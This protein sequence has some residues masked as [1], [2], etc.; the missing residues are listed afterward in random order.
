MRFHN[1]AASAA[2]EA[3][4]HRVPYRHT[5]ARFLSP[6]KYCHPSILN[7][8][9][10]AHVLDRFSRSARNARLTIMIRGL[11]L[12]KRLWL[13]LNME[14]VKNCKHGWKVHGLLVPLRQRVDPDCDVARGLLLLAKK[15]KG[16]RD[17][18]YSV[19]R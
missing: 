2:A 3:R 6:E 9:D 8:C 15:C 11:K 1:A 18:L 17:A 16:L 19:V 12:V 4:Q 7:C 10:I 13:I 5:V 14:I